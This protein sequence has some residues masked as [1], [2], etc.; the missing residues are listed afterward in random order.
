MDYH[1]LE[2]DYSHIEPMDLRNVLA[3]IQNQVR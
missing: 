3:S 2:L 1:L